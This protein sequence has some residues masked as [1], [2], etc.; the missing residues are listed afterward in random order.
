MGSRDTPGWVQTGE[1][2]ES[3]HDHGSKLESLL[4]PSS[5][6]AELPENIQEILGTDNTELSFLAS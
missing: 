4:E 3:L 2:G 1:P 6:V 5:Q